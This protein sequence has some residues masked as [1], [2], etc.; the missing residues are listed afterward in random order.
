MFK[1]GHDAPTYGIIDSIIG[2]GGTP[3]S[4]LHDIDA[5]KPGGSIKIRVKTYAHSLKLH[6]ER[7][8]D[9]SAKKE[10]L[11]HRIDQKRLE[12][13]GS[14]GSSSPTRAAAGPGAGAADSRKWRRASRDYQ[15]AGATDDRRG[16]G[17][18]TTPRRMA[19][20]GSVKLAI[21]RS[22]HRS[23]RAHMEE[24]TWELR[25]KQ[26]TRSACRCSAT[27]RHRGR[28][29]A[30]SRSEESGASSGLEA[31]KRALAST[32]DPARV[33]GEPARR[34]PPSWSPGLTMAHDFLVQ[35]ALRG[36]A[37]RSRCIDVPDNDALRYGKEF[38]N[39]G[40]CNPTYFTVGN[41]VKYLTELRDEQGLPD[42]RTIVDKY[43]FLTAGAC[44]PCRF[45]MY[46]T[47]YR[48]AL[49]DAGFDG[50]RVMLFQQKGGLKQATGE[51]AGLEMN[52]KFF[53]GLLKA[54]IAGDVINAMGYRMRPYE[55]EAGRDRPRA[56]SAVQEDASTTRF[57]DKTSRSWR[58][59][60][61]GAP[62]ARA[63]QVSTAPAA[64]R[65][66]SIIGEFWAMTTEGDGNYGLQRF[67]EPRAP[68]ATS[69]SSPPGSCSC[70]G[71][72]ATTP[73]CAPSCAATDQARKAL[74]DAGRRQEAGRACVVADLAIRAA[75]QRFGACIGLRGYHLP[76][77]DDIADDRA[78]VLQ[79]QPARRRRPHG[80]RQAHPQRA[81]QQ[82]PHDAVG[83]AVRLHAL[84]GRLRRRASR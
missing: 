54:I 63:G 69:S 66:V 22:R 12:L 70:S 81:P 78:Q 64:R 33:H 50:F 45:G 71:R 74:K 57:E 60:C 76:D 27:D 9:V 41:L 62:R 1:C 31:G 2:A 67:L 34:T 46:V 82:G 61:A 29:G 84:V 47:E 73:S 7:L 3:Y 30:P 75:F 26:R 16:Q 13:L 24:T 59:C 51:E 15:A 42:A 5:N 49:R 23:R 56:S 19:R 20:P 18:P 79:Q 11:A 21:K 55:V 65:K 43:V 36:S 17:G 72:V 35:G 39:R 38:G 10:E 44:G 8:E 83:E 68:S 4:A 52:P 77:M 37:T 28:A 32:D 58:R 53:I 40:Q 6:K 80:G 25:Q 14:S 48:K